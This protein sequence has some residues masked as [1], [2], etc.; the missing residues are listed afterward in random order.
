[1]NRRS[2]RSAMGTHKRDKSDS[3]RGVRRW[4]KR[5]LSLRRRRTLLS[6]AEAER[7]RHVLED[8]YRSAY[9]LSMHP[10]QRDPRVVPP[11]AVIEKVQGHNKA[12]PNTFL[13]SGYRQAAAHLRDLHAHG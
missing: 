9:G 13:G 12:D 6:A 1:M 4:V 10:L 5:L 11:V 2:T 8:L 7:Y 3:L